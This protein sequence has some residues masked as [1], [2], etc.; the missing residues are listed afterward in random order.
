MSMSSRSHEGGQGG[1]HNDNPVGDAHVEKRGSSSDN[2][3]ATQSA[4]RT[5]GYNGG[6]SIEAHR[7]S[8]AGQ[9]QG[10]SKKPRLAIPESAGQKRA[11]DAIDSGRKK[12]AKGVKS[13][14]TAD[15]DRKLAAVRKIVKDLSNKK[16]A[17]LGF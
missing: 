6:G 8:P 14:R 16:T 9:S 1:T 10:Q 2:Q 5:S 12:V 15:N 13:P 3:A 7:S 11:G 4:D 17:D